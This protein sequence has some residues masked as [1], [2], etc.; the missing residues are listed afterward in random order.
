MTEQFQTKDSGE[1]RAFDTGA[2]RDQS[3]GKG[4]YDLIP[5][6]MLRR[7]AA[8]YERGAAKY[9]DNNWQKGIP[10][11]S[12]IDSAFR[13]LT[14]LADGDRSE[15][16][17]AAVFF[18]VAGLEWTLKEVTATRLPGKLAAGTVFEGAGLDADAQTWREQ[19]AAAMKL[20][21]EKNRPWSDA[22]VYR[23]P[24]VNPV[25]LEPLMGPFGAIPEPA[26]QPSFD[27]AT[28]GPHQSCGTPSGWCAGMHGRND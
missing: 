4:R 26:R 7:W 17:A 2:V 23:T 21:A 9:G 15:D 22:E 12:F 1:R 25:P 28:H 8:L 10:L 3:A 5:R 6:D 16:H 24:T 19:A 14:Q 18:N 20:R 11:K 13:H 27:C